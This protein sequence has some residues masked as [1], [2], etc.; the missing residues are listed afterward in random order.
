[1]NQKRVLS[2]VTV[3]AVLVLYEISFESTVPGVGVEIVRLYMDS[4]FSILSI[5][6]STLDGR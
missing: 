1:M 6:S 5:R 3:T 4:L 2:L